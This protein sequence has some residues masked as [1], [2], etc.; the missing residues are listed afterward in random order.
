MKQVYLPNILRNLR[1]LKEL[2]SRIIYAFVSSLILFV[3]KVHHSFQYFIILIIMVEVVYVTKFIVCNVRCSIFSTLS[4]AK[5]FSKQFIFTRPQCSRKV[6]LHTTLGRLW[7][8]SKVSAGRVFLSRFHQTRLSR[9]SACRATP[10]FTPQ[11]KEHLFWLTHYCLL[12]YYI[13]IFDS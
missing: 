11:L 3:F 2:L 12:T 7:K 8:D 13:A 9:W 5:Y 1:L 6:I 10:T 4:W